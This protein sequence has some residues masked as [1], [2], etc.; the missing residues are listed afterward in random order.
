[1]FKYKAEPLSNEAI[2]DITGQLRKILGCSPR[3]PLNIIA[4]LEHAMPELYSEFNFVI[5]HQSEMS[6]DKHAYTDPE[7][8]EIVIREDIYERA[9]S[10]EGRDRF[11]IAHEIGHYIL[12]NTNLLKLTRVYPNEKIMPYEDVEWQA[13]AFAGELLCPS[14]AIIEMDVEMAADY[15]GVSIQAAKAQKRKAKR[16]LQ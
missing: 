12:H 4:I 9:R 7:T 10:G 14:S 2:I 15:Y 3:D 16:C 6:I 13:D 5:K 8:N 1:M 11:T